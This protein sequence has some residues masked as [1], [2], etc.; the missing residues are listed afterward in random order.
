[1]ALYKFVFNLT[2]TLAT[3]KLLEPKHVRTRGTDNRLVSDECNVRDL[4]EVVYQHMLGHLES[5]LTL[6]FWSGYKITFFAQCQICSHAVTCP[7]KYTSAQFTVGSGR[8]V[9]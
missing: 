1:M 7:A 3:E 2:L 9:G 8:L 4:G 6:V 5:I